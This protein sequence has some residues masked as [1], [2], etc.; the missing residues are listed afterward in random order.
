MAK[1][2][3]NSSW[4]IFSIVIKAF[5]LLPLLTGIADM[6]GGTWI[7]MQGGLQ[8]PHD[9]AIDPILNSQIKFWGAIWLGFGASLWWVSNEPHKRGTMFIILMSTLF[10]SGLGRALSYALFGSPGTVLTGAMA[11][12]LVGGLLFL[13]WHRQLNANTLV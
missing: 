10:L 11:I 7:L 6:V 9:V 3:Q 5:C 8:L 12:E 1:D 13:L 4:H 2:N